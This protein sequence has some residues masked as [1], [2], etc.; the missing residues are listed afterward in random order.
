VPRDDAE[1][2]R[3]AP[4]IKC[5]KLVGGTTTERWARFAVSSHG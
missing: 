5:A 3:A 1:F 2:N 4:R